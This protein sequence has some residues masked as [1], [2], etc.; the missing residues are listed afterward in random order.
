MKNRIL[1]SVSLLALAAVAVVMNGCKDTATDPT[2]V[3]LAE[4]RFANYHQ[5]DPIQ[6][7][8][9]PQNATPTDSLTRTATAMTY[10]IV[11]GYI[12]NL[13]TNRTAGM[14]Y[15]LVAMLAGTKT[16]VAYDD[17][18]L[19]PGDKK[20]WIISGNGGQ[21]GVFDHT[22]ID[23]IPP[24]NQSTDLAYFRFINVTPAYTNLD[25]LVGDPL[26]GKLLAGNVAYKSVSP[27]AGLTVARD[28]TVTFYVV[29]HNNGTVLSRLSGVGLSAGTYHTLTWGGEDQAHRI[30]D[31]TSGTLTLNDTVRIRIIGDD[32]QGTDVTT[33]APLTF[34]FN[35]INALIPPQFPNAKILD[36]MATGGLA[37]VINNNTVFD[38]Q[39]LDTFSL[40]P[41]SIRIPNDPTNPVYAVV[42]TTTNMVDKIYF[43]F[44]KPAF[45]NPSSSDNILFRF[46]AGSPRSSIK[47]DQLYA[48]VVFDTVR[49]PTSL[50]NA[51]YDSS[52]GTLTV[53]IPDIPKKDSA[54]IVLGYMLANPAPPLKNTANNKDSFYVDFGDGKGYI[55]DKSDYSTG[56]FAKNLGN[57]TKTFDS[58]L[59]VAADG[60]TI[61]IKSV[62][63]GFPDVPFSFVPE[64]GAIYEAFEVGRRGGTNGLRSDGKYGPHFM[65]IRVNP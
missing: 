60:R 58:S 6:I 41:A 30:P 1:L 64:S 20:T 12:N 34:R 55:L 22:L 5:I 48:V 54:R 11:T 21:G 29:D 7:Y 14:K 3:A 24:A 8:M 45:K 2:Y 42:P 9:Y 57:S 35:V 53:P 38:Y 65:V 13:P 44:L 31:P 46:F 26:G 23:D 43:E 50:I 27:Y 18:V 19:M 49:A 36:Y 37:I 61:N 59:V 40:A 17:V 32:E 52:G 15:H 10:G 4:L 25:I 51:G 33:T 47:S 16:I 56:R 39:G 28:T 62:L 63:S